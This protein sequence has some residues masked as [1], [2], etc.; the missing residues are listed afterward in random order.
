MNSQTEIVAIEQDGWHLGV[1]DTET[2]IR[3]EELGIRLGFER[4]RKV[5][6]L[7]ER[8]IKDGAAKRCLRAPCRGAHRNWH[9]RRDAR[10]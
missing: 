8:M 1:L 3:D 5:R 10:N 2:L 6:E 9:A 4:P 7:I